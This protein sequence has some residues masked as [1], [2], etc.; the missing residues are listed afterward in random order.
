M[1]EWSAEMQ[2][3][4][5]LCGG[6]SE[7]KSCDEGSDEYI[8]FFTVR[9]ILESAVFKTFEKFEFLGYTTQVVAETVF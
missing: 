8:L 4:A 5:H 6:H 3:D 7:L 1:V 2:H 9:E